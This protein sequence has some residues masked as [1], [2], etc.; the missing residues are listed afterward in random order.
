M[1]GLKI[2]FTNRALVRRSGTE[3]YI[4]DVAT[5]LLR[6]GHTPLVYAP[7]VG[8]IGEEL[9]RATIPVVDD[10]SR[11]SGP[12][13]IIHGQHHVEAMTAL[14]HFPGVPAVHFCHGWMPWEETPPLFPRILRYV[15]VDDTC[16]DR[17]LWEHGIPDQRVTVCLNFVDLERFQP[18]PP[19]PERPRKALVFS[20]YASDS[21][22]VEAVRKVCAQAGLQVDVVG[23]ASG[24]PTS[25]PETLLSQY[26][27]VF[28]KARCALEAM[29]VGAAVILYDA[30]GAGPMVTSAELSRLR[31]LNFG[32]RAQTGE[33]RPEVLLQE[34]RRYDAADAAEVSRRIRSEA[35]REQAVDS[36]ES[37][38]Q[39]VLA[40]WRAHG[41]AD[42]N[43]EGPAAAAY[44]RLVLERSRDQQEVLTHALEQVSD[45]T[46]ERLRRRLIKLPI[47]APVARRVLRRLAR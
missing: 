33:A 29:A 5:S 46:V 35:G 25:E 38:Y 14:L 43:A 13:D 30:A 44:L 9:R 24:A 45:S 42:P 39:E 4:R 41:P 7:R 34:I 32:I 1:A 23:H 16:R 18:R 36:L 26:D 47:I 8:G 17:L 2:L 10:L 6:R 11:L 28:A 19:L 3:L 21:T 22:H 27:L 37:I 12:P 31:R 15:A 20:N 40:E